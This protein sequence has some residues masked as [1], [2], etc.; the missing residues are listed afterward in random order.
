MNALEVAPGR[1]KF[2]PPDIDRVFFLTM[3]DFLGLL[4][5]W[6]VMLLAVK[7]LLEL[8]PPLLS[9]ERVFGSV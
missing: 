5:L 4:F 9:V 2:E 1:L 6:L 7:I 3:P 8:K